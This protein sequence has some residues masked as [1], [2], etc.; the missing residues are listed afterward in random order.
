MTANIGGGDTNLYRYA[1]GD[2]VDFSDPNGLISGCPNIR[3]GVQTA[4]VLFGALSGVSGVAGIA[5]E[6]GELEQSAARPPK[7]WPLLAP[8]RQW[9]RQPLRAQVLRGLAPW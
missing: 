9:G 4:G 5:E 6:A 7:E 1:G 3:K 2:P 8:A